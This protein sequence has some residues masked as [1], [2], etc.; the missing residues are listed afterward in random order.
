MLSILVEPFWLLQW[1]GF[2]SASASQP[3]YRKSSVYP[4]LSIERL[5][6]SSIGAACFH[7]GW[8]RVV[9]A[10][11]SSSLWNCFQELRAPKGSSGGHFIPPCSCP[12]FRQCEASCRLS[13]ACI[14]VFSP[15]VVIGSVAVV[16][17]SW[18]DRIAHTGAM[19]SLR[20]NDSRAA[21]LSAS[22][23]SGS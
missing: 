16:A 8:A 11:R 21:I 17:L 14:S 19:C 7:Q 23:T 1:Q 4:L 9:G 12:T 3:H 5:F 20:N 2:S 15:A 18:A 10:S 13:A 6:R 22:C